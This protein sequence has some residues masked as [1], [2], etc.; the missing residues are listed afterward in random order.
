MNQRRQSLRISVAVP[1]RNRSG[2][3]AHLLESLEAQTRPAFEVLII[4]SSSDKRTRDVVE[5]ARGSNL[6]RISYISHEPGVTSQRNRAIRESSGEVILFLDDDTE[7]AVDFLAVLETQFQANPEVMG[8]GGFIVNEWGRRVDRVW[9]FRKWAGLLQGVYEE[10]RALPFGICLPLSSLAPFQGL[11]RSDW[12]PGCA[13]A[14]RSLVFRQCEFS[15]FFTDY[16]LAEDKEFSVRVSRRHRLAVC[17]DAKLRHLQVRGGRPQG[18][19]MGYYHVRNHLYILHSCFPQ[20]S[21]YRHY[22][23]L[24]F[25]VFDAVVGVVCG[26]VKGQCNAKWPHALGLLWGV[27]THLHPSAPRANHRKALAPAGRDHRKDAGER[28]GTQMVR[29]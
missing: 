4:D 29:T 24:W 16:G 3:I 15:L 19:R 10:G 18:F 21:W 6:T 20:A 28:R 1:T 14:W 7:L 9:R 27:I 26:I 13:S 17:G 2:C 5:K 8:I 23:Q 11:R 22:Q 12:L 25:W